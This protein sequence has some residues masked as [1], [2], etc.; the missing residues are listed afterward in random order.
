M[1]DSFA[2]LGLP[3]RPFLSEE[4]ISI[5]Y[6]KLAREL[7]PDQEGGDADKFRELGRA[8]AILH[9]PAQRLREL[10]TDNS[11]N[12]IPGQAVELFPQIAAI[13]Q[14]ADS[15]IERYSLASNALTKA[16]LSAP[17]KSLTADLTAI[18]LSVRKWRISLEQE[19]IRFDA[20]WPA[21][22]STV[23]SQ[24]ANSFAYATRWE[25]ELKERELALE[26]ILG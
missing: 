7:H 1:R 16:L 17:L 26:A 22:G 18:L 19:L 20:S 2:V 3:R 11:G 8:A 4:E 15:F 9:D 23:L 13:L 24:L 12:Q 10:T 25:K 6:R 21:V 5:A 14:N